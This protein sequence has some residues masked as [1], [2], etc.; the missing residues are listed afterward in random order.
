MTITAAVAPGIATAVTLMMA[1]GSGWH[2]YTAV[3][4]GVLVGLGGWMVL[5]LVATQFVTIDR[6]YPAVYRQIYSRFQ[7]L[8]EQL[9]TVK[10]LLKE[11]VKEDPIAYALAEAQ[12]YRDLLQAVLVDGNT[13]T[14]CSPRDWIGALGYIRLWEQLHRIEEALILLA[15]LETALSDAW[16]DKLRLEGSTIGNRQELLDCLQESRERLSKKVPLEDFVNQSTPMEKYDSVIREKL[17]YV[18]RSINEFRDERWFGLVQARN[19]LFKTVALTGG[20]C[21]ALTAVA[22]MATAQDQE[23]NLTAA[24]AFF[25]VGAIV[26]LFNQLRLDAGAE[27]ATEDYGLTTARLFHTPLFSGLAALGG[28]LVIPMLS[29]LVNG[30]PPPEINTL[31]HIFTLTPS[32]L[33]LAVLF[34]LS[35]TALLSRLQQEA[36]RYKTDLRRSES[37][38]PGPVVDADASQRREQGS[39]QTGNQ[40]G[41][42]TRNQG[43]GDVPP[44]TGRDGSVERGTPTAPAREDPPR[45][46]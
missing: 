7:L 18:R 28:V 2:N 38:S 25:L 9:D 34:G 37:S 5:A 41:T 21:F 3:V 6:A 19:R 45:D 44:R 30:T 22:V 33:V 29:F 46:M 32:G 15:P 12:K 40:S 11:R 42:Q 27:A 23:T 1:I 16:H 14:Y 43:Q 31:G 8:Q 13:A 20:V 4:L 10:P 26:G 35:P 39:T 36:E 24:V 17:R